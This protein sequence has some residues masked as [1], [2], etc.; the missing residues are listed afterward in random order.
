[1]VKTKLPASGLL[2]ARETTC[3][4]RMKYVRADKATGIKSGGTSDFL[5]HLLPRSFPVP[6]RPTKKSC[7]SMPSRLCSR[8]IS[9]PIPNPFTDQ[10]PFRPIPSR[11]FVPSFPSH[12]HPAVNKRGLFPI[13]SLGS[14]QTKKQPAAAKRS[15]PVPRGAVI[16]KK[17]KHAW[18]YLQSARSENK[19]KL[20]KGCFPTETP[21]H[22][23]SFWKAC[24]RWGRVFATNASPRSRT[25]K[26]AMLLPSA[27]RG[28][29][30]NSKCVTFE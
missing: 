14:T 24:G 9:L 4:H 25:K 17:C 23:L 15:H 22:L 29:Q 30:Y 20:R 10:F 11:K 8:P 12:S 18:E 2:Q 1:M 5:S 21:D 7:S 16:E 6:S 27:A 19:Y 3:G 28:G 13:T 26:L